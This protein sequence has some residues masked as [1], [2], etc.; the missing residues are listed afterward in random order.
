MRETELTPR[1]MAILEAIVKYHIATGEPVGSKWLTGVLENAPSSATLR[2][3]MS[4]LCSL[5]FLAQP[6]TSAGRIPTSKGYEFYVSR[7]MSEDSLP[8]SLKETIDNEL[9]MASQ[10]TETLT[11]AAAEILSNITGLPVFYA[12]LSDDS[13]ALKR[14]EIMP[15]GAHLLM[16]VAFTSDGRT[17]NKLLKT[18]ANFD[19]EAV[20]RFSLLIK[21]NV[22]GKTLNELTVGNLQNVFLKSGI[23][24]LDF[25][26][27]VSAFVQMIR[28]IGKSDINL[29]GEHN[30]YLSDASSDEFI[31]FM[32][33]KEGILSIV[34]RPINEATVIFGSDTGYSALLGRCL[35][36]APF[37]TKDFPLGRIGVIGSTRMSYDRIL[38]S[39]AFIAARLCEHM[40][41]IF[42]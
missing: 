7:L 35:A 2:N 16:L 34:E 13:V 17:G 42:D 11:R 10:D 3:E 23:D 39:V 18:S 26:P 19:S 8:E 36:V 22:E 25:L 33:K 9:K 14:V 6:H 5:G 28:D 32:D 29:C 21:T 4:D 31:S 37:G 30:L 40:N 15:I 41:E 12:T 24:A 20:K 38:P 1:K 27:L